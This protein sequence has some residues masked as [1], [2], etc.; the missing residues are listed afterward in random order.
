[1]GFAFERIWSM[2]HR[3]LIFSCI[4]IVILLSLHL[5]T[6][7]T[8]HFAIYIFIMLFSLV[9]IIVSADVFL[10]GA[11]DLAKIM[12]VSEFLLGLTL[13]SVGTSLPEIALMQLPSPGDLSMQVGY[14]VF[15]Q[16]D[17]SVFFVFSEYRR[18]RNSS[19]SLCKTDL[20]SAPKGS[21]TLLT[22]EVGTAG[23][24]TFG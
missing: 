8:T 10:K 11:R 4:S 14:Q 1:M 18:K 9:V 13:V 15:R 6:R 20:S 24:A 19:R 22:A 3:D 21:A 16:H 12:G 17:G 5:A 23:R 7:Q 2:K